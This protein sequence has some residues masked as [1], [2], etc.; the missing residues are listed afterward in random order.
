MTLEKGELANDSP[1]TT[2]NNQ[3]YTLFHGDGAMRLSLFE[4]AADPYRE[5]VAAYPNQSEFTELLI[6]DC[7]FGQ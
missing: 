7:S 1:H 6:S 4:Q 2:T 5:L 3:A